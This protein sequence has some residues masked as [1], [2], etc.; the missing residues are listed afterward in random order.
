MRYG[1]GLDVGITSVGFATMMLND[2]DEPIRIIRM[3]SRIFDAAENP[4]TGASLALPRREKRGAR[5]LI[6]RR[7]LRKETIRKILCKYLEISESE[8]SS[9]YSSKNQL[10]DIYK[11]RSESLDRQLNKEEFVRLLIHLS[12]RRGFKSNRKVE[13]Q[14]KKSDDGKLLAAISQNETLLKDKGYR[15]IGEMLYKDPK[16][17]TYKRNKAENYSNT[18]ARSDYEKEIQLIFDSQRTLGNVKA[19]IEFEN[20]YLSCYLAQRPFDV[21]PG[22]NSPYGGNQIEKMLGKCTFEKEELR[23]VKASYSFEYFNLLSKVNAIKVKD[24][25]SQRSLS[26]EERDKVIQLAFAKNNISYASI[27]KAL[28]LSGNILFNISYSNDDYSDTEK[29]T[30]FSYLKAFHEI[31]KIIPDYVLWDIDKKNTLAYALSIYKNDEKIKEYLS[32]NKFSQSEIDMALSLPSFSKTCNLSIKAIKKITPFL[33]EG[34]I[35]SDACKNAGYDFQNKQSDK[36]VY[37]PQNSKKAPELDEITNP[38]VRR[39]ISQ[40]IKVVNAIIRDANESP[41]YVNI[42]LARELSKNRDERN[43]IEKKQEENRKIND[44]IVQELRDTFNITN[45]TGLDI[46]KYKLFKD[47]DGVCP[48]SLQSIEV[49]RLFEVGYVDVDHII[50]YSIS[51]DDSYNNK[52]LVL[53]K[54]NREKGNR[55]PLQYL[56]ESRKS[57]FITYVNNSHFKYKKKQNLLKEKLTDDD[58]GG[59]KNR[60]LQDTQYISKFLLNYFN[61]YLKLTDSNTNKKNNIIAVN[62]MA[63]AYIRKRWGIAKIREDGDSHHAVDAVVIA[64]FTQGLIQKISKYSKYY[65]S[66]YSSSLDDPSIILDEQT[67]EVIDKFPQPY[68]NFRRELE[69]RTSNNPSVVL[70]KSPIATYGTNEIVKPIF[71]SRMPRRKV[72]GAAH[73]ETY[74][75]LKEKDGVNYTVS[76]TSL[77]NLKLK[78]GEIQDYYMPESDKL[79]YDA[80]KARLQM[81]NGDAKRAFEEPMYKPKSDGTKGP[82]VK[83]VKTYEKA[84][85]SVPVLNNTAVADNGNMVRVD[86]FFV[87]GEGYYLVPIYV[88]DTKKPSLPNMAIVANKPYSQWKEMKEEDFVYSLY[89]NDLLKIVCNKEQKLSVVNE[90]STLPK[91]T[92]QKEFFAYYKKCSISTAS[93]S[94]INDDNTYYKPSLGVKGLLVLEKYSVDVIGNISKVN[95]EKRQGFSNGI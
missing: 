20:E 53:S 36:Q 63:T 43:K 6:R 61:K 11:I 74:R 91:E 35:Y 58:I 42:E 60:N 75:S 41:V 4:K 80:L 92:V 71:V 48:Y 87:S 12:Q 13:S 86:V 90:K 18:F 33:E 3:G 81:F 84:T 7:R 59:F 29:K 70:E 38:V 47:Q 77:Q 94:I 56:S 23:A 65:E 32:D 31:K 83:S 76:K 88:A 89:P 52:V 73:Q 27:R 19:T 85:L 68:T 55:I 49:S 10:E 64:C 44:K 82:I 37:L 66:R 21:G 39:S 15:T 2:K 40:T 62:G 34:M 54:E 9:I 26:K 50:P 17:E 93:I 8:I 28:G 45:P 22:G 14:D 1:I 51:F 57:E 25:N 79:L 46:V 16:F 72:T 78:N 30:K 69:M 5:R 95:K 24:S 67:G